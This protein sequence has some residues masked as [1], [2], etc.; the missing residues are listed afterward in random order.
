MHADRETDRQ[1]DRQT[2]TPHHKT[3]FPYDGGVTDF[4]V[5]AVDLRPITLFRCTGDEDP[6]GGVNRVSSLQHA[7]PRRA[8][9][10]VRHV[11]AA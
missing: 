11:T 3:Q 7:Q 5:H 2:E 1:T 10:H 8:S 9:L 6:V 4:R